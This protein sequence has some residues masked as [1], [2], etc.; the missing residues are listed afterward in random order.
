MH[1]NQKTI[2]LSH[3]NPILKLTFALAFSFFILFGTAQIASA[4]NTSTYYIP[5]P[6]YTYQ[7]DAYGNP[8]L[9]GQGAT[10]YQYS[11]A[12]N[13]CM[14]VNSGY[15]YGS[16]GAYNP[17]GSTAYP[18]Y[19]PTTGYNSYNPS[20]SY[21]TSYSAGY[22]NGYSSYNPYSGYGYG[23]TG[24]Y[25]YNSGYN[26]GYNS[27]SY[28]GATL[29][30]NG[31]YVQ[32]P[33]PSYTPYVRGAN[34]QLTLGATKSVPLYPVNIDGTPRT[35]YGSNYGTGSVYG[36]TPTYPLY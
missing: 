16:Y 35:G 6:G 18:N 23:A 27:D 20:Y 19:I 17:S 11:C 4:D 36:Y 33:Y 9:N 25:P 32:Y 34:G 22:P 8:I 28:L 29:L 26:P 10:Q 21:P 14:P 2:M 7:V 13:S 1:Q 31:N 24:Y 5:L 3:T 15:G 30:G 12:N